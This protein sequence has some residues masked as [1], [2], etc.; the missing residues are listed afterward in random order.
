[1]AALRADRGSA[2]VRRRREP[3]ADLVGRTP[4][5]LRLMLLTLGLDPQRKRLG[6][7]HDRRDLQP[8]SFCRPVADP[9]VERSAALQQDLPRLHDSLPRRKP[10]V[11]DIT[12][13][14]C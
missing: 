13:L 1:M 7:A 14:Y 11:H 8:S 5:D 10:V 4:D 3:D 6:N 12:S 2:V 9:A